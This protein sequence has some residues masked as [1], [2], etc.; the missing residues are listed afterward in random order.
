MMA[1]PGREN[2]NADVTESESAEATGCEEEAP[3]ESDNLV[4]LVLN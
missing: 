4:N 2:G 1:S 3:A